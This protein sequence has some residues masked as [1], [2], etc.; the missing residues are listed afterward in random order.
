MSS[1]SSLD[2]VAITKASPTHNREETL[3]AGNLIRSP[4]PNQITSH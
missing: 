2:E 1:P 3:Q 4:N